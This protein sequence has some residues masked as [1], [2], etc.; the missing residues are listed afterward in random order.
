MKK[1]AGSKALQKKVLASVLALGVM[2]VANV[3][4][5][6]E[7]TG[8]TWILAGGK[9]EPK[10]G[11]T[12][13]T[14]QTITNDAFTS[15]YSNQGASI[16]N[17][18]F[19]DIKIE[20]DGPNGGVLYSYSNEGKPSV[21]ITDSKFI[22]NVIKTTDNTGKIASI[23]LG[24]VLYSKGTNLVLNDV[25]F[26]GN[27]ALAPNSIA[28]A[29]AILLDAVDSGTYHASSDAVFNITKDMLYSGNNIEA[30]ITDKYA[31][32]YGNLAKSG[33]GFLFLDR[34]SSA[35]FNIADVATLTIGNADANGYMDSIASSIPKDPTSEKTPYAKIIKTGTGRLVL[36]SDFNDYYG[37][38]DVKAGTMD[39][40]KALKIKNDFSVVDGATLNL[41]DAEISEIKAESVT[42]IDGNG[43]ESS[44]SLTKK[45]GSLRANNATITA[46]SITNNIADGVVSFEKSNFTGKIT[47]GAGTSNLTFGDGNTWNL[48][49]ASSVTGL[50][51]HS[52][53]VLN[54]GD[55]SAYT[56][57]NY[58][59]TAGTATVAE[60]AKL[61]VTG[62][63][64]ATYNII[65]AKN[66]TNNM[67][68]ADVEADNALVDLSWGTDANKMDL[69]A[70]AKTADE[71]AESGIVTA[72]A[73]AMLGEIVSDMATGSVA[74]ESAAA[75][76]FIEEATSGMTQG[77]TTAAVAATLNSALQ[78]AES[79]G[80]SGNAITVVNNVAGVATQRLSFTQ[81]APSVR[82]GHGPEEAEDKDGSG[83]WAQYVHGKDKVD[84]MPLDGMTNSY[85]SQYNGV[86]MGYDFKKSGKFQ[87]GIAF[88]YGEGDSYSVN[89]SIGTNSDF[90]FYGIGYYAS[91]KNADSNIMFDLNY[92]KSDSDV[93]QHSVQTLT[94]NPVAKTFSAGVKLE[95]LIENK[96][97]QVVP[98]AGLRYMHVAS[99]D[100][101]A[102]SSKGKVFGYSVDDQNIWLIPV[103][104]SIRQENIYESGWKVTPKFDLSYI[105][106]LGDTDSSMTVSIP[107]VAAVSNLGY[108]VMDNGSFLGTIGIEAAKKDWT[109][110]LN[111]SYQKGEYA[112]SDKFFA[113]VRYSF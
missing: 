71:L 41:Q 16:K 18:T 47:T 19:Q 94:A 2:G 13:T 34:D 45:T 74:S 22:N 21:E 1:L 17:V 75:A 90:K 55:G 29:G 65:D 112:R 48:T 6:A 4:G 100:Y 111:Y 27:K 54:I 30:G 59:V 79:G 53:A 83:I 63:K 84:D 68:I 37:T 62:V 70:T 57:G 76:S 3:A 113:E 9:W 92:S 103:G 93:T 106:A 88:N 36:N 109:F 87:N 64:E 107:G 31:Y 69:V 66:L 99:D 43:K 49:G 80:A 10:E 32:T 77:N 81:S 28:C 38:L 12:Y 52:G 26:T 72:G 97:V 5:A 23:A 35:T 39:I 40:N 102:Y 98:Y 7:I 108:T 33:G 67:A 60:G 44:Y 85:R 14:S 8:T 104:V 73:A 96:G 78:I 110:G 95:K 101:A 50:T 86:I 24:G 11:E 89:S 105:W 42:M 25:E 58:A 61:V 82:G 51:L 15:F 46:N 20:C 56:N 91:V